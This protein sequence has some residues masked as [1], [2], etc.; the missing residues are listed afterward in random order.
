M[1]GY[2]YHVPLNREWSYAPERMPEYWGGFQ[3]EMVPYQQPFPDPMMYQMPGPS[4]AGYMQPSFQESY[5]PEYPPFQPMP[6]QI[7][8]EGSFPGSGVM[9]PMPSVQQPYQKQQA[10]PYSPFDNPLQP[11]KRP[12]QFQQPLYNPYPNQ[13]YMQKPQP[14][15]F[16]SVMNQFKTQDGSVDITKMMNTAGQVMNT[17]SQVSTMVKGVG[18]FFKI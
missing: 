10:A 16:K 11:T 15:T 5:Q 14:S 2:D 7:I 8:P 13:Q 6:Q 12:P 18:G 3:Q 4:P 17:V 1:I 9:Q